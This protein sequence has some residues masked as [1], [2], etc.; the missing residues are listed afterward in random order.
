MIEKLWT[1]PFIYLS[2]NFLSYQMRMTTHMKLCIKGL[3]KC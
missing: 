1:H 3:D 2:H